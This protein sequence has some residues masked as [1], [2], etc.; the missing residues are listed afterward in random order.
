MAIRLG[1]HEPLEVAEPPGHRHA[2]TG[3]RGLEPLVEPAQ[4][5]LERLSGLPE[6]RRRLANTQCRRDDLMVERRNEHL[7]AVVERDTDPIQE[8][9]LGS[10]GPGR[11]PHRRCSQLVDELVDAGRGER[12]RCGGAAD[13]LLP[14]QPHA[15]SGAAAVRAPRV[16]RSRWAMTCSYVY[17]GATCSEIV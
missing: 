10:D 1:G 11:D 7:D 5:I 2:E 9:L 16:I 13:E 8:M 12:R 3:R 15:R 6:L 4:C 14:G 17:G